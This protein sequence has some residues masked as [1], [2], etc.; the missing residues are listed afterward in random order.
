[1]KKVLLF[2]S[3]LLLSTSF[4]AQETEQKNEK[5]SGHL[6][7]SKFKQ[8]HE[9][10]PTPNK[11]HTASGAPGYEYTHQQVDYKMNI[12]LDEENNKIYGEETITYHNNSKDALEYLWVQ[13]DQNMRAPNSKTNDIKGG[14]PDALYSPSKFTKSFMGKP[15]QGG[16]NIEHI[17]DA[18]GN[19]IDYMINK[20]MMRINLSKPIAAGESFV[21]D[22]KWWYNINDYTAD[23]GRSGYEPLPD[24]NN[25]YIIAQ[26]FPRLAVYNNVEGWQNLQFWGRSEFALE[27]GNYDVSIT[28]PKDHILNGTGVIQNPKD[29]LSKK[30]HKRYQQAQETFDN[31]IYIVTPED[32]LE[33]AKGKTKGTK[34]WKLYAENVRDFAFTSS[35]KLLW[36][37]MAVD[38]NGKTRNGIF[39]VSKRRKSFMGRT[40]N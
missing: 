12:V 14:G 13:L 5:Q 32:A 34:T 23:R 29:V 26:F 39:I 28:T 6:N 36:D 10:L 17:V 30:Q 2:L 25:L 24:G 7:I 15:F 18:N 3:I 37:A 38:I 22:I 9:E 11:Q 35:R 40:L 19:A 33:T 1:M 27:F 21:F 20:T 16:F 8:L 4:F 31:P